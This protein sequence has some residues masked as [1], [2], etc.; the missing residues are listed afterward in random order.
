MYLFIWRVIGLIILFESTANKFV[1]VSIYRPLI[2][3]LAGKESVW[4]TL[5][6]TVQQ[7]AL[8]V[9]S[10]FQKLIISKIKHS[11]NLISPA[12]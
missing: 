4:V 10:E 9:D 12:I 8:N 5:S 7:V 11:T 2:E 3:E 1:L 6:P